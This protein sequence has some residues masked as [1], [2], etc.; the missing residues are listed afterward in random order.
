MQKNFKKLCG[1]VLAL[2]LCL[3]AAPAGAEGEPEPVETPCAVFT[4]GSQ[5]Y[6]RDGQPVTD[7]SVQAPFR[8]EKTECSMVPVKWLAEL[9]GFTAPEKTGAGNYEI[10]RN[11]CSIFFYPDDLYYTCYME[12]W[13]LDNPLDD[14][15]EPEIV[16]TVSCLFHVRKQEINGELYL[17]ARAFLEMLWYRVEWEE[18]TKQIKVYPP[19]YSTIC[20][21]TLKQ[22]RTTGSLVAYLENHAELPL[23]VNH[24]DTGSL[25]EAAIYSMEGEKLV[26]ITDLEGGTFNDF[27][28]NLVFGGNERVRLDSTGAFEF[29]LPEGQYIV[30]YRPEA[31]A[32]FAGEMI[33][34]P[35]AE[36]VISVPY[37]EN[38]KAVEQLQGIPYVRLEKNEN[39]RR[40]IVEVWFASFE[41]T[42]A[43]Y[44][45]LKE[46]AEQSEQPGQSKQCFLS[47]YLA[48]EYL[49]QARPSGE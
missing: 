34:L 36:T 3:S 43:G 2:G 38:E 14:A 25:R 22:N 48:D 19:D 1:M 30:R 23:F 32:V 4:I 41:D 46:L 13:D 49:N 31:R 9:T 42:R 24:L 33:E 18:E 15:Y 29:F 39:D 21:V 7:T 17:P 12:N 10:T 44:W 6:L 26:N 5:T 20:A 37:R 16:E 47:C 8:E 28:E 45:K 40:G 35:E 11:N 27:P